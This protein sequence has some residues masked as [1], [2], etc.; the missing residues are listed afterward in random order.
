MPLYSSR[1]L[2]TA[3]EACRLEGVTASKLEAMY[4]MHMITLLLD[5]TCTSV[6]REA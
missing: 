1:C 2:A 5:D 6:K 3:V 4:D